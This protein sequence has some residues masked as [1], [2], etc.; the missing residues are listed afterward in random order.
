MRATVG[1]AAQTASESGRDVLA[2]AVKSLSSLAKLAQGAE[3]CRDSGDLS[4]LHEAIESLAHGL[5]AIADI[6][7]P[8][9]D[10][11]NVTATQEQQAIL[12][13][14]SRV[15]DA[16]AQQS[17]RVD[18]VWPT[19]Y[20]ERAIPVHVDT[21]KKVSVIG[22]R[23]LSSIAVSALVATIQPLVKEL[24]PKGFTG[25]KFLADVAA[26]YDS[27]A[28]RDR[29]QVQIFDVYKSLVI[30]C[31]GVRFWRDARESDFEGMNVEQFRA[32]LSQT[33]EEG[34]TRTSD[35]RSLRLLPPLNA[36]D[37][38]YLYQPAEARFGFIG[39]IEFVPDT[40]NAR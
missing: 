13:L 17:W 36:A 10:L 7:G 38:L 33:L 24:I 25:A 20:I 39:R 1:R 28:S 11:L 15:R 2:N 6:S 35:G 14:E 18:G 8:L 40:E 22:T 29:S 3:R 9:N 4:G 23:K 16:C 19:L 12:E 26:A 31:Q 34:K 37:G 27:V 5:S 21:T 30:R 32:R